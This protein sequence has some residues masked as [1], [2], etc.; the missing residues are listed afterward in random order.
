VA[1][2]SQETYKNDIL[3]LFVTHLSKMEFETKKDAVHIFNSLLRRQIGSRWPTV[4]Y[5]CTQEKMLGNL[6]HGYENPDVALNSGMMLRE[7]LKHESLARIV[8]YSPHF[9]KF[10]NYVEFTTF[11]VSSDAF[12][13]FKDLL[14]RH[15]PMVADFLKQNYDTFFDHYDRL[16]R[17]DNYVTKRQ[18]LKLL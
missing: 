17:S 1:Q 15:K 11:D 12:A 14:T 3:P 10:F 18:S 6:V 2:L 16:L 8:L 4:E 7:C 5:L 9:Y 13:S